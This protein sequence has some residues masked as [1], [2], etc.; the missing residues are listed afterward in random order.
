MKNIITFKRVWQQLKADLKGRG[1][2]RGITLTYPWLANQFGHISLGFIPAIILC[3]FSVVDNFYAALC[4]SIAW[5]IFKIYN[6]LGPL[7]SKKESYSD[8]VFIPKNH[9]I[10]LNQNGVMLLLIRLPMFVFLL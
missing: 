7:L 2:F 3:R 4:V 9:L 10:N 5:L 8:L 6:F 1:S